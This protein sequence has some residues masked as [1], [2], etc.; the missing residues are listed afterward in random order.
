MWHDVMNLRVNVAEETS[1]TWIIYVTNQNVDGILL[2]RVIHTICGKELIRL[3]A[4]YTCTH[5]Y[6]VHICTCDE[7]N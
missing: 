5:A 6:F 7:T 2:P 1:K 4:I 3:H